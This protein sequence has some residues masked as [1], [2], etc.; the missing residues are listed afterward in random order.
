MSFD[1]REIVIWFSKMIAT[2]I[3]WCIMIVAIIAVGV[4]IWGFYIFIFKPYKPGEEPY[5]DWIRGKKKP[6][7]SSYVLPYDVNNFYTPLKYLS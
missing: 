7:Q 2:V 4:V 3:N 1:H 6:A 5:R